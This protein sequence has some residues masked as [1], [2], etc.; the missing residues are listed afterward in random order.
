MKKMILLC[1]VL[2][3]HTLTLPAFARVRYACPS[4]ERDHISQLAISKS[5][6]I[7][8]LVLTPLNDAS[9]AIMKSATKNVSDTVDVTP[10]S[11]YDDINSVCVYQLSVNGTHHGDASIKV[12]SNF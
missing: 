9:I 1:L 3:M 4:L 8:Q 12:R 2:L 7:N 6:V 11:E 5:L 10:Q